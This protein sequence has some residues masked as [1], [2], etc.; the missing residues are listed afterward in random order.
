MLIPLDRSV[1]DGAVLTYAKRIARP[2]QAKLAVVHIVPPPRSL[3]PGALR[4]AE[5]YVDCVALGL[6][7]EGFTA[8]AFVGSGDPPAQI[9]QLALDLPAEM[10][11]MCTRGRSGVGKLALGSVA[12]AIASMLPVPV[13]LV[14]SSANGAAA[15]SEPPDV[16][17]RAA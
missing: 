12:D 5:A 10:I 9:V 3:M 16:S 14:A 15:G 11:A 17:A 6:R 4:V 1:R 2:L 13:L 8:E 7:E